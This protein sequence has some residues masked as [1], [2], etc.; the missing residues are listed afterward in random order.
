[1]ASR[2]VAWAGVR[3]V[4]TERF[5]QCPG[6]AAIAAAVAQVETVELALWTEPDTEWTAGAS[7]SEYERRDRRFPSA[8][9]RLNEGWNS[10]FEYN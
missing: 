10:E 1:M 4:G 9:D 5:V 3:L 8:S 2:R 7:E 6:L